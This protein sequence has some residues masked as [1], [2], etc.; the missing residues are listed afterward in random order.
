[1]EQLSI[2]NFY[3]REIANPSSSDGKQGDSSMFPPLGDGFTTD[4][5]EA[6][7]NPD[8]LPLWQPSIPYEELDIGSVR[9]G[10]GCITVTGRV[11]NYS[12]RVDGSRPG[13]PSGYH[14]LYVQDDTGVIAV[15]LNMPWAPHRL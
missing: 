3:Q 9:P 15:R 2:Q 11:V 6:V 1:M 7:V 4:E 13:K 12:K 8:G 10:P 14:Y 5:I